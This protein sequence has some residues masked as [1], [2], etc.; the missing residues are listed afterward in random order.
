MAKTTEQLALNNWNPW[1]SDGEG[2]HT[3]AQIQSAGIAY[4]SQQ[5][6]A[7]TARLR[8]IDSSLNAIKHYFHGL[9]DI[10]FR[11]LIKAKATDAR[12]RLNKRIISAI[13]CDHCQ[14]PM[15]NPC[16]NAANDNVRKP[17]VQRVRAYEAGA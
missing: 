4:M 5:S 12:R 2:N 6:K 13:G 17:H 14:V 16:V 10:G 7:Q 15:H 3:H 8:G 11:D 1:E 9:D